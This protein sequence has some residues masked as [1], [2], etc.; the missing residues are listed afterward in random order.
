MEEF[1]TNPELEPKDYF[2]FIK[3]KI[4][5]VQKETLEQNMLFLSKE[6]EKA[7]SLGQKTLSHKSAYMWEIL[8]KEMVLVSLGYNKFV[9]RQDVVKMIDSIK[10]K[11]SVKIIELENY[12]RVIPDENVEIIKKIRDLEIF[13]L[14]VVVYTDFT[15]EEVNT[16]VQKEFV[17]KNRDPII[18]GMFLNDKINLKHDRLYFITDWEDEFC[19]LT[20]SKMLDKMSQLGIKD[21]E[22]TITVDHAHINRLVVQSMSEVKS[23]KDLRYEDLKPKEKKSFIFRFID[24]FR[25]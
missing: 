1:E 17:A 3:G 10:P 19:D 15:N 18:F 16:P 4:T 22:K 25:K 2:E 9:Y 20:F 11:N 23:I 21:P 8:Q 5:E 12:P 13:D 24:K 14:L 6:I 7:H